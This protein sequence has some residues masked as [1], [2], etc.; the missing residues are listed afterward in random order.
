MG[1]LLYGNEVIVTSNL[2]SGILF[3]WVSD[4]YVE[5]LNQIP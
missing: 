4:L 1:W 2:I 5:F 3:A